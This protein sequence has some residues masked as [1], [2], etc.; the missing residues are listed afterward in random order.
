MTGK[1]Q[2]I[3]V[4]LF[5]NWSQISNRRNQISLLLIKVSATIGDPLT[6]IKTLGKIRHFEFLRS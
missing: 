3:G 4:S 5:P 6:K 1:S 2:V